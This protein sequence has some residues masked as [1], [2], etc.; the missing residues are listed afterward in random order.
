MKKLFSLLLAFG[1]IYTAAF[2]AFGALAKGE[3]AGIDATDFAGT[4]E[5]VVKN[6][7]ITHAGK[8]ITELS[9][10]SNLRARPGDVILIKLS[11]NMFLKADGTAF[12]S[13]TDTVSYAALK[14]ADI[15]AVQVTTR[16][17]GIASTT[18]ED[19]DTGAFVKLE[20]TK[21]LAYLNQSF[22][23]ALYLNVNGSRETA[24]RIN[25]KGRVAT[26][27][28][29]IYADKSYEDISGGDGIKAMA[30]IANF[31]FYLG[32]GVSVT[33]NITR[34]ITYYGVAS[35]DMQPADEALYLKYRDLAD[36][37]RLQTVNLKTE[38]NTV[39]FEM[40]DTYYLY[41]TRGEYIG[42]S[43]QPLPYWTTYYVC[44]EKYPRLDVQSVSA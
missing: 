16:G 35:N 1:M 25:I 31:E 42:T 41:N 10:L 3:I 20:F 27:V 36:I 33:R 4:L 2:G 19:T 32:Q 6:G 44:F 28:F 18:I 9:Q 34:G 23:F 40:D 7:G 21:G 26:D 14:E 8:R 43:D 39:R 38:G 30:N 12:G 15:R 24:T 37:Y 13:V 11:A 17:P 29:E 22:S 5:E